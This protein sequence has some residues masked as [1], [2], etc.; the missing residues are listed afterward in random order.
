M[1]FLIDW[2]DTYT[3]VTSFGSGD[4]TKKEVV[5]SIIL[6]RA[7]RSVDALKVDRHALRLVEK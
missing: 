2:V 4:L 6:M 1:G 7:W 3:M 5:C